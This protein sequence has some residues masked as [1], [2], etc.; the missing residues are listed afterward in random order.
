MITNQPSL[1]ILSQGHAL[2]I[3]SNALS[4]LESS[5]LSAIG[6]LNLSQLCQ[7]ALTIFRM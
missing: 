1:V 3:S 2:S 7:I 6:L 4:V 5:S